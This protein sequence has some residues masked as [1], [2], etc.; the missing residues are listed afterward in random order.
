VA[1]LSKAGDAIREAMANGTPS[2]CK[3]RLQALVTET[4]VEARDAIYPTYRLPNGPVRGMSG[5][6]GRSLHNANRMPLIA[7]PR[8]AV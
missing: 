2:Q 7:A 5:V 4:R 3:A 8:M 1:D 6:V